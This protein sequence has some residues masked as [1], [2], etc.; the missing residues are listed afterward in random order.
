MN[1]VAYSAK[2]GQNLLLVAGREGRVGKRPVSL[3]NST[4][5]DRALFV[6]IPAKRDDLVDGVERNAVQTFGAL[7]RNINADFLHH[8]HGHRMKL[9]WRCAGA[10]NLMPVASLAREALG[11]LA[12]A[13][14]V[15]AK[16]Q[17][18][19]LICF[20]SDCG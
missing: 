19:L 6:G 18:R 13:R 7:P 9:S 12:A 11:H 4:F 1:F 16:K 2:S 20:G 5:Q 15:G 10:E 14:V 8:P 17:N 3:L